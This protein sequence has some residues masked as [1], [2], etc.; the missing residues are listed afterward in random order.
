ML[1]DALSHEKTLSILDCPCIAELILTTELEDGSNS[2]T[3]L[4]INDI[5]MS[6]SPQESGNSLYYNAR[7][8]HE[9][10]V[11]SSEKLRTINR[12]TSVVFGCGP[13]TAFML[14]CWSI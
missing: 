9:P 6:M 14:D 11:S 12:G 3:S 4:F 10:L 2:F 13:M 5:A 8:T 7:L 1:L